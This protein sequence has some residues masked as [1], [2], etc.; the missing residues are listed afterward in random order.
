MASRRVHAGCV[1][2]RRPLLFYVDAIRGSRKWATM[3]AGGGSGPS[4]TRPSHL[5][6]KHGTKLNRNTENEDKVEGHIN[7]RYR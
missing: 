1:P 3:A 6:A 4:L 2:L 5:T 7:K